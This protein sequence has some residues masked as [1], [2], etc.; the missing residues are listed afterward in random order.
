MNRLTLMCVEYI[1]KYFNGSLDAFRS[2]LNSAFKTF[3][4]EY[5]LE[6]LRNILLDPSHEQ[7]LTVSRRNELLN[8]F[9]Q[10]CESLFNK[11]NIFFWYSTMSYSGSQL[12]SVLI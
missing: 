11:K 4:H 9:G 5:D 10:K 7:S 8:L 12:V 3:L 2:N 6:F 1:D